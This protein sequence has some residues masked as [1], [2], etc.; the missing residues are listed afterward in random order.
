MKNNFT[1][2]ARVLLAT[3]FATAHISCR[4]VAPIDDSL[5]IPTLYGIN[6]I[7]LGMSGEELKRMFP[8]SKISNLNERATLMALDPAPKIPKP[9]TVMPWGTL[10]DERLVA[11]SFNLNYLADA[12]PTRKQFMEYQSELERACIEAWGA[13]DFGPAATSRD[14]RSFRLL[15]WNKEKY[16]ATLQLLQNGILKDGTLTKLEVVGAVGVM[17]EK[18]SREQRELARK[19]REFK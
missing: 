15:E 3:S 17:A 19:A 14:G 4:S 7:R 1:V 10:I 13:P 8:E 5:A 9:L 16:K 18:T 12:A 11:F 6:G 2:A